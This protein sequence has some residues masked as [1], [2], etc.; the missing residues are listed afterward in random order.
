MTY[1][2]PM[3]RIEDPDTVEELVECTVVKEKFMC[4][5]TAIKPGFRKK[6]FVDDYFTWLIR[7]GY[8]RLKE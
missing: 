7:Q 6:Y 5:V 3:S 1:I 4:I 8:I 2:L